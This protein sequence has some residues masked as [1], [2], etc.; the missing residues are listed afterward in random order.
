M[1]DIDIRCSIGRDIPDGKQTSCT[2][3]QQPELAMNRA[4]GKMDFAPNPETPRPDPQ[5]VRDNLILSLPKLVNGILL[6]SQLEETRIA[7]PVSFSEEYVDEVVAVLTYVAG[8]AE[9]STDGKSYRQMFELIVEAQCRSFSWDFSDGPVP[10][11]KDWEW[12]IHSNPTVLLVE[13]EGD[14]LLTC[15]ERFALD[16]VR[17]ASVQPLSWEDEDLETETKQQQLR[18]FWKNLRPPTGDIRTNIKELPFE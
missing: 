1:F 17:V 13:L 6:E 4:V 9:H 3:H 7:R 10:P 8:S 16:V 15:A 18:S 14:F 5:T 2:C 12:F 11:R